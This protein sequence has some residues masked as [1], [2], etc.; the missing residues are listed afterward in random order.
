[1]KKTIEMW[2]RTLKNRL[3][4]CLLLLPLLGNAQ[5]SADCSG[6]IILCSDTTVLITGNSTGEP[7]FADSDN[8]PGCLE[9][10]ETR[11]RWFYFEFEDN[12]PANSSLEFVLTALEAFPPDY[13]FALYGPNLSCDSLGH[14]VRCSFAWFVAGPATGLASGYTDTTETFDS[15]GFLAPLQVQP[16]EGYYLFINDFWGGSAGFD[17]DFRGSAADYLNC[18]ANPNCD[19]MVVNAGPD[20]TACSGEIPYQLSGTATYTNGAETY[21][22]RGVNGEEAFLDDPNIAR[23]TITFPDNFS[24]T[25]QYILEVQNGSCIQSD[26]LQLVVWPAPVLSI[27]GPDTICSGAAA[28]LDAGAGFDTYLWSNGDQTPETLADSSGAYSITITDINGCIA[29]DTIMVTELSLPSPGL[30]DVVNVCEDST[31]VLSAGGQFETYEWS[32]TQTSSDITVSQAG[33]YYLTVTDTNGCE[34]QD[35]VL[36]QTLSAP[37]PMLQNSYSVCTGAAISI[38]AAP[39]LSS[40]EWST[41]DTVTAIS[42]QIPGDY[43]LTAT[44]S[45][46]CQSITTFSV[47]NFPEPEVAI[48]GPDSLCQ[49]AA[50]LLDAGDGF[51]NYQWQDNTPSQQILV[52]NGGTYS[53]TVADG[54]GCTASDTLEVAL[55]PPPDIN[56]PSALSFCENGMLVIDAGAGYSAYQWSDTSTGQSLQI[57]QAGLYGLTVTDANGCQNNLGIAVSQLPAPEITLS[58]EFFFC[59]G[60]STSISLD[61]AGLA[62]LNWSTGG[63]SPTETFDTP[64]QYTVSVIDTNGCVADY[65]F[66]VLELAPTQVSISGDTVFCEGA[67]TLLDAGFGYVSYHWSTG[68]VGSA[69][70]V[71][72]TGEYI[73]TVTNALGCEGQDTLVVASQAP[74]FS[75]L[76]DTALLCENGSLLL[77]AGSGLAAYSWSTGATGPAIEVDQAGL[78]SVILADSLGC[79]AQAEVEVLEVSVP[80][81][82]IDGGLSLCPGQSSTLTAAGDYVSYQWSTGETE[83]SI[84]VNQSG[85]Y[86]LTVTNAFG[87]QGVDNIQVDSVPGPTVDITGAQNFCE[88]SSVLLDAG[89]QDSY[90]WMDGSTGPQLLVTDSGQYSVTVWNIF[91][92]AASD[93]VSLVAFP[94]PDPSLPQEA[95]LCEGSTANL[96]AQAGYVDYVWQNGASGPTLE[97]D[98]PGWYSVLATDANGC[99]GQDSVL[100]LLSAAPAPEIAGNQNLC[101]GDSTILTA[102]PG[103]V[104][105]QWSTGDTLSTT[106]VFG[107]GNYSLTVIDTVGCLGT[108]DIDVSVLLAPSLQISGGNGL[109]EGSSLTLDAGQHTSYLWSD[110]SMERQLTIFEPGEFS[111]TIT[112]L[113]GCTAS[114]TVQVGYFPPTQAFIIGDTTFC[115]GSRTNLAASGSPGAYEWSTGETGPDIDVEQ[116]GE[117]SLVVT[118]ANGCR[119]T[120]SVMV[121]TISLPQADAGSGPDIDCQATVV[122]LGGGTTPADNLVYQWSGPGINL[123]N[124]HLPAPMVNLPGLYTLVVTDTASNCVS[125][126]AEALVEDLRYSP[127]VALTV[128]DTLDCVTPLANINGQGSAEGPAYV[129]QWFD[130]A[131]Q[132][133][134][135]VT[136]LAFGAA[137]PGVYILQVLD[138]ITGCQSQAEA[139]V[140]ANFELPVVEAGEGG[141]LT[142]AVEQL[143]LSATVQNS[144]NQP[145]QWFT[146][147]GHILEGAETLSPLVDKPGWYFLTVENP[148]NGCQA[149]DSVWV[150][151]DIAQPV[152]DAGAEQQLD[153]TA[154]EVLLDGTASSQGPGLRYEWV[155][156]NG[157]TASGALELVVDQAGSYVLTVIDLENGCS[158]SDTVLV[159]E[160][161][162]YLRGINTEILPPLCYGQS[163]GAIVISGVQGGTPPYLYSFNGEAFSTVQNFSNLS[164]GQYDIQAQDA[165]GCEYELSIPLP[166]GNQVLLEL[167]ES[168]E[169]RLGEQVWLHAITNLAPNEIQQFQ[170]IPGEGL[171]CDTCLLVRFRPLESTLFKAT[172]VDTNGCSTSDIVSVIVR[173]DREVYIPNAF[174][175]NGDGSNDEFVI[176]AGPDV[177][178]IRHLTIL[179]RW[180]GLVFEQK[181][182]PPNNPTYGWNGTRNGQPFDP[183]VFV[184]MVEIEFIDEAVVLYKGDVNLL[185]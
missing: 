115:E 46:G 117:Y 106:A 5:V 25:A 148:G 32:T 95:V 160:L 84:V 100:V 96:Q 2:C 23:P 13:D 124:E 28:T 128:E 22:W 126:M 101:P 17:F 107:A 181:D 121:E 81:P 34:G 155:S 125:E 94:I 97:V 108:D 39:G 71:D 113:Q 35:S 145:L 61:T 168:Q 59:P 24:G 167:G 179:D 19:L 80:V 83:S 109:C 41:G 77:D 162:N 10:I 93:T 60:G 29:A 134:A 48:I 44:D 135:G 147:T 173:R 176:F 1:M 144:E 14:P 105:Y 49:G 118:D 65:A 112:D 165:L 75:V 20:S 55:L 166:E 4:Y 87:C 16:G 114:E 139:T 70:V 161:D 62:G 119:D 15:D 140:S 163:N 149:T 88:G 185:R 174:S 68:A 171:P 79:M 98:A 50:A 90:Q 146:P 172:I 9:T 69:I 150:Q 26:T 151:Q 159:A 6:A 178:R 58:G 63:I 154:Q 137:A 47:L 99:M 72:S 116:A 157:I 104:S 85:A 103:F 169:I 76:P 40:Y 170:W 182:F 141:W 86:A 82:N 54:N 111:V 18:N 36:L 8:D 27:A 37:D 136:G 33:W 73:V 45:N 51:S 52:N 67:S 92:C 138:T 183:A 129:Y 153:C 142:C 11:G 53:V 42:I 66:Q 177:T 78:Y 184:Y 122:M 127:P 64:G 130:G 7:D 158:N 152:A 74:P 91:G 143:P 110:G 31:V 56:V 131:G 12:M 156:D 21:S 38:E 3:L 133:V 164:A 30:P 43:T 180:G 57:M 175:P 89:L 120:V 132:P 123:T 102:G